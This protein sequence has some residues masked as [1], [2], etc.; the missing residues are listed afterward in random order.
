MVDRVSPEKRSEIMSKIRSKNTQPEMIVR[1][2]LHAHGYRFRLHRKDL[3]GTPDIILPKYKTVIFVHGCF[4]HGHK[5][6][7]KASFPKTRT[8][9]WKSKIQNN[10]NRDNWTTDVLKQKGWNV[11]TIWECQVQDRSYQNIIEAELTQ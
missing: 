1:K 9:W 11:I 2:W 3:P 7:K 5:G 10:V 4:W 8:E 6:C